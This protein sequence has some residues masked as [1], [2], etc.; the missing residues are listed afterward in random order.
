MDLR[1]E[2]KIAS[3]LIRKTI[4][5]KK[6]VHFCKYKDTGVTFFEIQHYTTCEWHQASDGYSDS[7]E[8]TKYLN[9]ALVKSSDNDNATYHHNV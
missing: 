3:Q 1:C 5:L 6:Q 4:N 9:V 7:N 2:D 8:L